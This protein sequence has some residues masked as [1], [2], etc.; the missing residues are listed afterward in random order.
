MKVV[1]VTDGKRHFAEERMS[2]DQCC[3]DPTVSETEL[4]IGLSRR[5]IVMMT[6]SLDFA[7]VS[8][9]RCIVKDDS[10]VRCCFKKNTELFDDA[11]EHF[12][13]E[14]LTL[15]SDAGHVVEYVPE[16]VAESGGLE[17]L[18]NGSSSGDGEECSGEE[19]QEECFDG[20]FQFAVEAHGD[21]AKLFE[22]ELLSLLKQG[23]PFQGTE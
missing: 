18:G 15:A 3:D 13:E 1:F 7:T 12:V 20:R 22:G 10:D 19:R 14:F 8:F 4:G 5:R 9:C 17:P 21:G 2:D 16:V 11:L 6:C 23:S